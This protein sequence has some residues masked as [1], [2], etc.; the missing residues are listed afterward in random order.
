MTQSL[1]GPWGER[2]RAFDVAVRRLG[3]R[4]G[5]GATSGL[6]HG[7]N[8]GIVIQFRTSNPVGRRV[9]ILLR[10]P[11]SFEG[12]SPEFCFEQW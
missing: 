1:D 5:G 7:G 2:A 8:D 11:L 12:I 9:K 4:G 6:S 3:R 10:Y